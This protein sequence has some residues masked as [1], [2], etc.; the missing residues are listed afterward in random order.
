MLVTLSRP[1]RFPRS[2]LAVAASAV[3]VA[4]ILGITAV[5][6]VQDNDFPPFTM[7]IEVWY[8]ELTS[9][10]PGAII[11]RLEYRSI[12]DW[13]MTVLSHSGDPRYNGSTRTVKNDSRSFFDG[14]TRFVFGRDATGEPPE[15]PDQWLAP[16][17]L[18]VLGQ[19]GFD[20]SPAAAGQAAFTHRDSA[21]IGGALHPVVKRV[22]FDART[23][24]PLT[25]ET[26][27][28][29][30]LK[31]SRSYSLESAVTR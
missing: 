5:G 12:R 27:V 31:E 4:L 17:L 8:A 22:V 23:E 30:V 29:G 14:L 24:L 28:D 3:V 6:R 20:P 26:Y 7:R 16:G 19:Q 18:R 9:A 13:T 25:V 1:P 2:A 10:G 11:S 15:V 21:R